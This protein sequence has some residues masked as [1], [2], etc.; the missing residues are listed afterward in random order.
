MAQKLKET[1]SSDITFAAIHDTDGNNFGPDNSIIL[2]SKLG[3]G[4]PLGKTQTD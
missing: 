2:K 4:K 1:F 3:S